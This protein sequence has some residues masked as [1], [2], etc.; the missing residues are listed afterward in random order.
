MICH[1]LY[2]IWLEMEGE[3]THAF[4]QLSLILIPFY[5]LPLKRV[6]LLDASELQAYGDRYIR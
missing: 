3:V 1:I 2:P 4:G 6:S 5:A